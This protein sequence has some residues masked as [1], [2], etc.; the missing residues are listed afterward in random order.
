MLG[1]SHGQLENPQDFQAEN[2]GFLDK[3]KTKRRT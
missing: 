2:C 3:M 1:D